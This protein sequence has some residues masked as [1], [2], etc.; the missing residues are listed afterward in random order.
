MAQN[1]D[2]GNINKFGFVV[3][4]YKNFTYQN[5]EPKFITNFLIKKFVPH[6]TC[7]ISYILLTLNNSKKFLMNKLCWSV[8]SSY[9]SYVNNTLF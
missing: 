7:T 1:F 6:C 4:D 5:F 3:A 8:V 9:I 2:E